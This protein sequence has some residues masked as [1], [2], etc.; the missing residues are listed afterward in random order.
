MAWY[1]NPETNQLEEQDE[2]TQGV[3]LSGSRGAGGQSTSSAAPSNA[4]TQTTSGNFTDINKYIAL[5]QP[6]SEALGQRVA[7]GIDENVTTANTS[8]DQGQ[9]EFNDALT[10]ANPG[11]SQAEIKKLASD[12]AKLTEFVKDPTNVERFTTTGA[13]NYSG[14]NAFSDIG[15][16]AD[17]IKNVGTAAKAPEQIKNEGGRQELIKDVYS[18]P[19]RA[20]AGMLGLDS[21]LV[22][23]S[24]GAMKPVEDSAKAAG[25]LNQR[26]TDIQ[27]NAN[28]AITAQKEAVQGRAGDIQNAFLGET[29]AYNRLKSG[30]DKRVANL[31][32]EATKYRDEAKNYLDKD[33]LRSQ[34]IISDFTPPTP[35]GFVD[36]YVMPSETRIDPS[37]VNISAKALG[38]LGITKNQYVDLLNKW[39]SPPERV[40]ALD[41][42]WQGVDF[43]SP[44]YV[45]FGSPTSAGINR[46]NVATD[47]EYETLSALSTLFGDQIDS[48]FINTPDQAGSYKTDLTDFNY[49]DLLNYLSNPTYLGPNVTS[50]R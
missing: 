19:S 44:D 7:S 40:N 28:T 50:R 9:Q 24:P 42:S 12:P 49:Q 14:P 48:G 8:I 2:T 5:N 17:L 29:G 6:Q 13:G 34:G 1:L 41:P 46:G 18:D 47:Q 23:Q 21:A 45:S 27:N 35:S 3:D 16:Y 15:S 43:S 38:Q 10:A 36:G 31:S 30:I 22:K 37:K 20:K 33:W 25:D 39:A 32:T 11:M 26:V 4:A